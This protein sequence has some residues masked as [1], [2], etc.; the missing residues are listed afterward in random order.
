MACTTETYSRM[1]TGEDSATVTSKDLHRH[2]SRS[3]IEAQAG[4]S[5]LLR[6]PLADV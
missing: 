3:H 6:S 4:M 1:L 2:L 5:H